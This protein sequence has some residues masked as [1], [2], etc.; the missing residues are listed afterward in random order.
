MIK[1]DD[2]W[3]KEQVNQQGFDRISD[4]YLGEYL[5]GKL[6]LFGYENR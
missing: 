1:K 3:L 4:V 5:S 6:N 2:E